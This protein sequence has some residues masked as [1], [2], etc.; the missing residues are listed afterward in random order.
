MVW[1]APS[2]FQSVIKIKPETRFMPCF[3][4]YKLIEN[5]NYSLGTHITGLGSLGQTTRQMPIGRAWG[6][7][8]FE[9]HPIFLACTICLVKT[10]KNIRC[11]SF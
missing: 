9:L 4:L 5:T 1:Y 2:S 11:T 3:T 10:R 8:T 7:K 6:C